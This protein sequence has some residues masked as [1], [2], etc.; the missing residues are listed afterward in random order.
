MIE[1]IEQIDLCSESG[2]T[3][4]PNEIRIVLDPHHPDC[5]ISFIDA[6]GKPVFSLGND[7]ICDLIE[8]LE[9]FAL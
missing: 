1:V 6:E 5:P 4:H 3:G 9:R 2:K 7:E 8:A